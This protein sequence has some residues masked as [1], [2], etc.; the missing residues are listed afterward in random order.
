M[1]RKMTQHYK[2][3]PDIEKRITVWNLRCAAEYME[4]ARDSGRAYNI[5]KALDLLSSN[6]RVVK[7]YREIELNV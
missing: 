5:R 3:V 2:K 7:D 1:V 6:W 4:D